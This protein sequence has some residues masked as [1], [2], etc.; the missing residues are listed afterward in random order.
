MPSL[1]FGAGSALGE[2]VI[3]GFLKTFPGKAI[4]YFAS[5]QGM[6]GIMG[7]LFFIVLR[8]LGLPDTAI[9]LLV[10][11]TVIPYLISFIWLNNEKKRYPYIP[12]P[13]ELS[14]AEHSNLTI[15]GKD[16][17]NEGVVD[18]QNLTCENFLQIFRKAGLLIFNLV[19][20][21]FLSLIIITSFTVAQ[22]SMILDEQP[23]RADEMLYKSSFVI[24]Q[25]CFQIGVFLGRSSLPFFKF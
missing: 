8:P 4:G 25:L 10:I 13:E 22:T 6:A 9:Y 24:F 17:H 14:E 18:N 5:G 23:E 1:L 7:T 21:V 15:V 19:L 20:I 12:R 11:P 2:A 16:L 3:L